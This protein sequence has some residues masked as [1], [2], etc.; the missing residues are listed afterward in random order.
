MGSSPFVPFTPGSAPMVPGVPTLFPGGAP[1]AL[2]TLVSADAA[3]ILGAIGQSQWGIFDQNG[4]PLLTVDSVA[5]FEY[6]R[7]YRISDYPQEQ[8]AF[9]SY[10]KVQTPYVAKFGMLIGSNRDAFLN[11]IEAQLASL[12]FVAIVTP[13]IRYASANLVHYGYRRVVRNGVTLILVEVWCEEVR[14][15]AT[16]Q[17]ANAQQAG[18]QISPTAAGSAVGIGADATATAT[19]NG[20]ITLNG[21]TV[22]PQ[23]TTTGPPNFS[24]GLPAPAGITSGALDTSDFYTGD[25]MPAVPNGVA[26][27]SAPQQ[28]EIVAQGNANS[29]AAAIISPPDANGNVIVGYGTAGVDF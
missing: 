6:A 15:T 24:A 14:V 10:N 27:L 18:S 1:V 8:G 17:S 7:D 2:P 4:G 22:Q 13:E 12:N 28:G 3:S 5:S 20:Q 25:G 23:A 21:G 29:A 19:I 9:E 11:Q 26:A 16:S